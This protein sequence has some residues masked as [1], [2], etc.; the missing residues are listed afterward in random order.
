M[1]P[2]DQKQR[3]QEVRKT[4]ANRDLYPFIPA[5]LIRHMDQLV[6][7]D[8]ENRALEATL[9]NPEMVIPAVNSMF[10]TASR[11]TGL[12]SDE[13]LRRTDF[14][15]NDVAPE[16]IESAFAEV[17]AIN[18]LDVE[19]FV[20]IE[21]LRAGKGKKADISARREHTPYAVEVATS[22]YDAAGR[23]SPEQMSDWLIGRA[24][25][26]G[27][28]AQLDQTVGDLGAGRGALIGIVD[29]NAP[30]IFQEHPAFLRAARMAWE[31]LGR[32]EEKHVCLVTGRETVG[33]G[34]DD[35]VYPP[36]PG[37]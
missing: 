11:I 24:K 12:D 30:V 36:W 1:E 15:P 23:Y 33:I 34:R 14:H 2:A 29:T 20:D 32:P 22:I 8:V 7:K 26:D 6:E 37:S 17:R 18:F 9:A 13:I 3:W 21:P 16:R 19:G 27:K 28:I 5:D 31:Q 25:A 4:Y 35:A 10:R